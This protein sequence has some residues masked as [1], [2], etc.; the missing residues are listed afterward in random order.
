MSPATPE[1]EHG[2]SRARPACVSPPGF[3]RLE[4]GIPWGAWSPIDGATVVAG[5]AAGATFPILDPEV[6]PYHLSLRRE[7]GALV[8]E[9]LS[10]SAPIWFAGRRIRH[11]RLRSPCR[12]VLGSTRLFLLPPPDTLSASHL[13][14]STLR[15]WLRPCPETGLP[16]AAHLLATLG[17][18]CDRRSTGVCHQ[19]LAL[20]RLGSLSRSSVRSLRRVVPPGVPLWRVG[21]DLCAF[22]LFAPRHG[23]AGC[24]AFGRGVCVPCASA[25]HDPLRL[26]RRAL[27]ALRSRPGGQAPRA[28]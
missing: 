20:V 10:E 12:I 3:V 28:S 25:G 26:L 7:Q 1:A 21:P 4:A 27:D 8:L 15:A 5:S 13:A 17:E 19:H 9:A 16:P 2:A 14:L 24:P 18:G 11:A 22:Q 23:Q 6:G